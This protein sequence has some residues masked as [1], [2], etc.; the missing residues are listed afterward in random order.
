MDIY[1]ILFG[2]DT[3]SSSSLR[4]QI[5]SSIIFVTGVAIIHINIETI[6]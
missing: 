5:L 2:Y 6:F 3:D 1:F 4:R